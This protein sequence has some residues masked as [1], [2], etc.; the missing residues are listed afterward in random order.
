M[1]KRFRKD[2]QIRQLNE[3]NETAGADPEAVARGERD[4]KARKAEV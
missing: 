4:G 2:C 3:E 1:E